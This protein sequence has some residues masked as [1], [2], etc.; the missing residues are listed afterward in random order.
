MCAR[1]GHIEQLTNGSQELAQALDLLLFGILHVT[2][3]LL[4]T[5]VHG[6]FRKHLK[7]EQLVAPMNFECR[8]L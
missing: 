2:K 1:L 4:D 8:Y 3:E 5:L 6:A 7:F